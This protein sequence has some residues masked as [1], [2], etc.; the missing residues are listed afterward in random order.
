[1]KIIIVGD[2]HAGKT[3]FVRAYFHGPFREEYH[4]SLG[5]DTALTTF[6]DN[7]EGELI[8]VSDAGGMCFSPQH[9]YPSASVVLII[10]D[11]DT[12]NPF[13][14]V[15]KWIDD[16]DQGNKTVPR[17]L[18]GTKSDI[19]AQGM[20][21]KNDRKQ[22]G[23]RFNIPYIEL[24]AKEPETIDKL[25]HNLLP[26]LSN[27]ETPKP[28]YQFIWDKTDGTDWLKTKALLKDYAKENNPLS[29]LFH[30]HRKRHHTDAVHKILINIER[31]DYYPDFFDRL[32]PDLKSLI[33]NPHGS[34]AR[35]IAFIEKNIGR[36]YLHS[37]PALEKS[38]PSPGN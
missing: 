16:I 17:L 1:M 2:R 19:A 20:M 14:V 28:S 35:R 13:H 24:N 22:Q 27:I 6:N 4:A 26:Y 38:Q 8:D 3:A 32:I 23:E 29:L 18:I 7:C 25:F 21:A 10:I 11:I 34:L 31:N 15:P 30:G 5:A 37:P 9:F 12:E 36:L 33:I